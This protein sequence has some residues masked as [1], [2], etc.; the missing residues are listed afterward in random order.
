MVETA[1]KLPYL[2]GLL[3]VSVKFYML[4]IKIS[5]FLYETGVSSGSDRTILYF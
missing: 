2:E 4:C 5:L 3:A 1:K